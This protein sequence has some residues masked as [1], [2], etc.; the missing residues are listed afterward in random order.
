[1][2]TSENKLFSVRKAL[3]P[4]GIGVLVVVLMFLHDARSENFGEIIESFDFSWRALWGLLAALVFVGGREFGLTWR[5]RMLTDREL[6]WKK[7]FKVDMLCEFTSCV[8]PTAVGGSS[9]GMVFLNSQGIEFGRATTLMIT[10]LLL[11]E[12]FFVVS[13]PIVI[14]LMPP[15][16]IFASGGVGFERGI[17]LT[18]WLIYAGIAVWT[19]LLFL[20]III[21]PKAVSAML[22]GLFRLRFLKRWKHKAE[23]LGANMIA[24]SKSLRGKPAWFW[25]EAFGAT[26]VSWISRFLVVNALFW[27]FVPETDGSQ[28]LVL[29]RQFVIWVILMVS[30]T[31]G[32][33]GLS[34]WLF[35]EYY[36][37]VVSV[38]GVALILAVMWR[39]LSYYVYLL[40][41]AFIVPRWVGETIDRIKR[42]KK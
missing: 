28:L 21:K 12:L 30:P 24:T 17:R 36:A 34:E 42:H 14:A 1:M 18:F 31:P 8:T 13:C 39:V 40:Y 23:E 3:I 11:D 20:G 7:A 41:G 27:A 35:S 15:A 10:T 22:T 25:V 37:D 33:A 38:A 26:S 9:L 6:S 29:S 32:G 19:L 2:Q 5:F 4:V 16:E